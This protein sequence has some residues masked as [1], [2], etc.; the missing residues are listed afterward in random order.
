M[1]WVILL[2]LELNP[3]LPPALPAG[4]PGPPLSE[5]CSYTYILPCRLCYNPK[6]ICSHY[7]SSTSWLPSQCFILEVVHPICL[8]GLRTT[9]GIYLFVCLHSPHRQLLLFRRLVWSL[10]EPAGPRYV[11]LLTARLLR[12]VCLSVLWAVVIITQPVVFFRACNCTS[13]HNLGLDLR[14]QGVN[15]LV[16]TT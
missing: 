12:F 14:S 13:C 3:A 6:Y 10:L 8:P 4:V 5:I 9:S 16:V 7:P 11:Y 15:V 1:C 2:F